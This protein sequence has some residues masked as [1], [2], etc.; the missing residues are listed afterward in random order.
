[1]RSIRRENAESTASGWNPEHSSCSSPGSVY[2]P[3]RVPPPIVGAASSTRTST[4]SAAR[5][6]AA[7]S[8]LGP[9]PTTTAWVM[10]SL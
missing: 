9:L 4:P 7:A 5:V 10:Q 3:L 8:P 2:S 6:T 1:M